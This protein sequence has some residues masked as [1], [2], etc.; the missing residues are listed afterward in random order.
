MHPEF[1]P[2]PLI[3]I[4]SKLRGNVLLHDALRIKRA[5]TKGLN[6]A[7]TLQPKAR[8]LK[9]KR[10]FKTIVCRL[11]DPSLVNTTTIPNN[12][13]LYMQVDSSLNEAIIM[14]HLPKHTPTVR[15]VR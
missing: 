10:E 12:A 15:S 11:E 13:D 7:N 2:P 5:Y 9:L 8:S 1:P 6:T 14:G 4:Q 3:D